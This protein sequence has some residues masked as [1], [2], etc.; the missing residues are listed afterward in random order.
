MAY[1]RKKRLASGT[2]TAGEMGKLYGSVSATGTGIGCGIYVD[3]SGSV[4]VSGCDK[5]IYKYAPAQQ[6]LRRL[7]CKTTSIDKAVTAVFRDFEEKMDVSS[8][9]PDLGVILVTA[10]GIPFVSFKCAHFPWAY[11]DKGYVYYGCARNERFSE[12]FDV[13]ERPLDCMCEDSD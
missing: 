8:P 3:Q 6:I 5:A 7:R 13:L 2:S 9:K 1:D 4:S 12:K 10:E 11:C